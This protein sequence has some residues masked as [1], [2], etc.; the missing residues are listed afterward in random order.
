MT[1][2]TK[3]VYSSIESCPGDRHYPGLRRRIFFIEKSKIVQWPERPTVDTENV[4]MESLAAYSGDFSLLSDSY[5]NYLDLKDQSSNATFEPVGEQGSRL[6][7]NKLHAV[8][9]GMSDA[10]K[11]FSAQAVDED[12]VYVYQQRDGK[13]CVIGNDEF[14]CKTDPSGDTGTDV[15]GTM[16]TSFD[17]Q[18]YDEVPVPSYTGKLLISKNEYMDCSDG[19]IKSTAG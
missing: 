1:C 19:K 16:T 17:I 13:F 11:G 9:A 10:V 7:T 15:N 14:I 12:M 4:T 3:S 5:F 2:T 8:M 18:V 6:F